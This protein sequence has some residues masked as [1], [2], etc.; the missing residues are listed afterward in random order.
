MA[1]LTK[2]KLLEELEKGLSQTAIAK[3]YGL[4]QSA[5]SQRVRRINADG[6]STARRPSSKSRTTAVA[7]KSEPS[8]PPMNVRAVSSGGRI[9]QGEKGEIY[10][11]DSLTTN[12]YRQ[13]TFDAQIRAGLT[14]LKLPVQTANWEIKCKNKEIT[15]LIYNNLI[16]WWDLF[17]TS[18]LTAVEFG[19]SAFEKR[20][21]EED[22]K[23]L[24]RHPL[25]LYPDSVKIKQNAKTG[26]F[27]GI[28]QQVSYVTQEEVTI[29][30]TKSF[31]FTNMK[32][33][34]FGN[35]YGIS[36]LKAAY[37]FWYAAR[38]NY[39]FANTFFETFSSPLVKGFA[40]KGTQDIR[41]DRG[42]KT[43]ETSNIDAMMGI[44]ANLRTRSAATLPWTPDKRWDIEFM[45][46]KRTGADFVDYIR[47]LD[48]MKI[49]AMF[50]PDLIFGHGGERGSYALGKV[51][52]RVF[53]KSVDGMLSAV[54]FHLDRY[55]LP[56][57]VEYN[58]GPNAD[59]AEWI[60]EPPSK[61]DRETLETV[62]TELVKDGAI[63]PDID[64]MAERLGI[65]MPKN[66][67]GN[68]PKRFKS[69]VTDI[70]DKQNDAVLKKV[71]DITQYKNKVANAERWSQSKVPVGWTK[72]LED[73]LRNELIELGYSAAK[74]K[75]T[76]KRVAQSRNSDVVCKVLEMIEEHQH[77]SSDKI[78]SK[79]KSELIDMRDRIAYYL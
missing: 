29:P 3:K 63:N 50:V 1:T 10:N 30:A 36:K 46:A 47:Y 43:G 27:D 70:V 19:Y 59:Q 11:P 69:K 22:G 52:Y 51:H 55:L 31:I 32:G 48:L 7:V 33:E 8:S 73:T 28:I 61:E 23:Y 57:L 9:F 6:V 21:K 17:M 39:D 13:M 41:D 76:A 4:S 72:A 56:Q 38:Y 5:V 45:E 26:D 20:W 66:A 44:I 68:A 58:F 78:V 49:R 14:V 15:D 64:T 67:D 53:L 62:F 34:S 54:K 12:V 77:E 65:P 24:Y 2:A 16:Q 35:L 71:A 79:V 74:A 18:L 60:F 42:N 25:D 37:K 40:P 75:Y